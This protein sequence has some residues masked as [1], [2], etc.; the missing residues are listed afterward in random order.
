MTFAVMIFLV[1][2]IAYWKVAWFSILVMVLNGEIFL[3]TDYQ[4]IAL[5]LFASL[6]QSSFILE[7]KFSWQ[8]LCQKYMGYHKKGNSQ[9][10]YL[11]HI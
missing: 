7:R 3:M 11:T 6:L 9:K 1:I 5:I 8:E 10:I 4:N 2:L